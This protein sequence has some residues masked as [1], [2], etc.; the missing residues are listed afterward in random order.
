M[1][2]TS[3]SLHLGNAL[4]AIKRWAALQDD[5]DPFSASWICT[6][7]PSPRT[8]RCCGTARWSPQRSTWRWV[9]TRSAARSSCKAMC[10]PYATGLGAGLFHGF[11]SGV[12]DDAVQRQVD[13]PG[14]RVDDR[15]VIHLPGAAGADVLAYDTELVPVGEDQRQHLELARDVAQRFN[16]RSRIPSSCPSC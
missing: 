1:Q 14:R 5:Y 4:G 8:R 15:G 10:P 7:S 3:D 2:P 16:S 12:A 6:R 11:R 9:S 13:A